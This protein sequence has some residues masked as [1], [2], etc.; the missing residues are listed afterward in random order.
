[1]RILLIRHGDPDYE[2]DTV[3]EK[4]KREAKLLADRLIHERID[5]A[6]VS[7][8]GR[9]RDTA[10]PTLKAKNITPTYCDWLREFCARQIHRPDRPD[11]EKICW[12][13]LPQDW[14]R[15][16]EFF[17][18]D[19]WFDQPVMAEV[20]MKEY[21]TEITDALDKMLEAHGY[22]RDGHLYRAIRP[23]DDTLALFCHFGV[24]CILIGHMIGI[25]PM[26]LWHGLAAAP[27]SVTTIYTE[28]RREG[29]A[30]FRVTCYG[31]TTH[32][33]DAGEPISFSARFCEQYTNMD[34]RHD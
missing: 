34:E 7:T 4:G 1:M 29:I 27:T 5:E 32:L 8:M 9:A 15:Y 11:I 12:D 26:P 14:M 28:E 6:F 31:D 17:R 23:N 21:A 33:H 20:G 16:E 18:Y 2:N 19:E 22:K 30:S 13:W 3:T 25:S 10:E 24:G